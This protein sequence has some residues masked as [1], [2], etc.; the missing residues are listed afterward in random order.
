MAE[1]PS[2]A[3]LLVSHNRRDL[4]VRAVRSLGTPATMRLRI[5][6]FDDAST[7]GTAEAVLAEAPDT[8][9]IRGTGDAFWNG[10]L[11]RAWQAALNL[12]VDA[13]LWLN[14][15]VALD[16][17]ALDRLGA[18]W[19]AQR[20][21]GEDAAILVGATRGNDGRLTYGGMRRRRNPLT[22]K[23][24]LQPIASELQRVDTFNG[25]IVLIQRAVTDRIGIND[26]AYFHKF[27][28]VDYGLTATAAGIPS[29]VL[30]GTLGVCE[31]N[32]PV[33]YG[34][35]SLRKR[36]AVVNSHRG[37]PMNGWWRLVRRHS[38]RWCVPHFLSAYARVFTAR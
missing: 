1:V 7:D 30:P 18:Q 27:G 20:A 13:F 9:V 24:E 6:L 29:Y 19:A 28:D 16:G 26:G 33:L 17:D 5:V 10:G 22:L 14:D 12:P 8:L 34:T 15:D 35:M 31:T 23:L 3:V 11:Y 36:W 4:T 38:G 25:N 37:L 21:R 2:V 32:P